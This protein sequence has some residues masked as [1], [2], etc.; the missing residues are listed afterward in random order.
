MAKKRTFEIAF[1]GLK[2][3]VHEFIYELDEKFFAERGEQ[4]FTHPTAKIRMLLEK[5]S[6]FLL[7]TFEVG[8]QVS[9]HCDRCGN[10]L[11]IDLWDEFKMVVKLVEKAKVI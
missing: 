4:D 5:H 11:T 2:P 7:L 9:S 8:G 1:V 3:G 6:G 10:P